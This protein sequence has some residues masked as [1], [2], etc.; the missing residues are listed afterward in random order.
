MEETKRFDQ[1]IHDHCDEKAK[2]ATARYYESLG[3]EVTTDPEGQYGIDLYA[4]MNGKTLWIEVEMRP[5]CWIGELWRYSTIHVL[6]RKLKFLESREDNFRL[7]ACNTECT[8][9]VIVKG[10]D[11]RNSGEIHLPNYLVL[12][13]ETF[14]DVCMSR[15]GVVDLG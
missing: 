9:A 5:S 11:I 14:V 15:C 12:G 13:P 3:Y 4:E 2:L 10:V 7:V 8:R 1:R 6:G